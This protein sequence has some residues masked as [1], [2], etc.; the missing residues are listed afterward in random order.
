MRIVRKYA[1]ARFHHV[2]QYLKC[3]RTRR[4]TILAMI[5]EMEM[6]PLLQHLPIQ[7]YLSQIPLLRNHLNAKNNQI[8]R[9]PAPTYPLHH[10]TT[11]I[12]SI[13]LC[14]QGDK[15]VKQVR[16]L[17]QQHRPMMIRLL[18]PVNYCEK[19]ILLRVCIH[20]SRTPCINVGRGLV[21]VAEGEGEE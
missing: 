13:T 16:E 17:P 14:T 8:S 19:L 6:R 3:P 4:M 15:N 10:E 9:H 7:R 11:R 12:L 18:E 1:A 5:Q 21:N 2:Q 20:S